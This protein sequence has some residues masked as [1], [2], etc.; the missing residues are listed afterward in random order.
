MAARAVARALLADP[1]SRHW[2]YSLA[3]QSDIPS[4][5]LYPILARMEA[6]KWLASD[7]DNPDD[8][9]PRRRY[10]RLT[11]TGRTELAGFVEGVQR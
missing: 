5:V 11:D 3:Q 4:G 8:T 10:Y 2:G 1:D 6:E 9:G 7:W